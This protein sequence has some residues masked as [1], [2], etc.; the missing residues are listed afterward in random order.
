MICTS[1]ISCLFSGLAKNDKNMCMFV[2][3]SRPAFLATLKVWLFR[4]G[5]GGGGGGGGKPD[6]KAVNHD[7]LV[8]F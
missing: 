3:F 4:S 6:T 7:I 8:N 2:L 1:V 5:G